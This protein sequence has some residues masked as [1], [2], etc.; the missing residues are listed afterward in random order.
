MLKKLLIVIIIFGFLSIIAS[1]AA[2]AYFYQF[3]TRDLPR[4]DRVD[5]YVM[6]SVTSVFSDDHTL[7]GEFFDERRYPIRLR[8]VP[9]HVRNS[10]LA[11]E[12]ASFYKHAGIDPVSI[13]RAVVKNVQT[14]S[15]SQ[16]GSTITQQVVKNILLTSEKKLDRKIK[17]AILSYRLEKKLSKDDILQLYLNQIYFGNGAYGIKAAALNYF[18]KDLNQLTIGESALLAGLPKAPSRFSPVTNMKAAKRRQGYVI[19][20]MIQAGFIT[21][22]QGQQALAEDIKVYQFSQD[23]LLQAPYYVSEVRRIFDERW[24]D[25]DID[26]DGLKIYTALNLQAYNFAELSTRVGLREVDKR[27][28]WRGALRT[29][30]RLDLNQYR[31]DFADRLT[32]PLKSNEVYPALITEVALSKGKVHLIVGSEPGVLN[33][34]DLGWA[35]KFLRS[36]DK[37]EFIKPE[38]YFEAGQV[39][40]VVLPGTQE[41]STKIKEFNLDQTPQLEAALVLLEP[42]SGKVVTVIGGYDYRRSQF[43]RATQSKRQPGS[44]FKPI[45]YLAAIDGFNY[46][47]ATIVQDAPQ[48]FKIGDQ[49][50][51]PGNYDESYLGPITLRTALEKSKN[52][53]SAGIVSK[54]GVDAVIGYARKMGIE[55]PLGRNLSLSLGSSEVAPLEIVRAYG[56][57]AARG[58][59]FPS[60]FIT[61]VEDRNGRVLFDYEEEKLLNAH[62]EI[63]ESSAFVMAYMMKGVVQHGTGYRVRAIERPVA[64]K[65]G[66]S[67]DQMDA[68]FVGYTPE[69]ACGVWVGFDEKKEI[70]EKETG[71]RVSAPIWLYTM[72]DF[73]NLQ[74]KLK[75]ER[76]TQEAKEESERLGIP[77]VAPEKIVPADF[78]PPDGVESAWIDKASGQPASEGASGAILEY[79]LKGSA[80]GQHVAEQSNAEYWDDPNL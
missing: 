36:D 61:R 52:L 58:V 4:I 67:N 43:N 38:S 33:L 71:G 27:R 72:T 25:Y 56:V 50:W 68:W 64:A 17:E 51:T 48:T 77:Y 66:T 1:C 76:L 9:L 2:A 19:D 53:V 44:S 23:R 30:D 78:S 8:E 22:E 42:G 74:D 32:L 24:R 73:L 41:N 63:S 70:G 18:K 29:Y 54:I 60:T 39:I 26:R 62:R 13:L 14:G 20:Q 45:V 37:V 49:Y 65:T 34:K 46:T 47:P 35:K 21:A 7:V 5:D 40:E 57:F 79:F 59:L 80:P 69:W 3:Y 55:S 11:A 10:F 12:D 75:L 6:S 28:G 31:S 15:A 16:G